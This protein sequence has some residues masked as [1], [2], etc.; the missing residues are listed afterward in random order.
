MR[1]GKRPERRARFVFR[2]PIEHGSTGWGFF[3]QRPPAGP[4]CI[5]LTPCA[6]VPADVQTQS[7]RTPSMPRARRCESIRRNG[8]VQSAG[9]EAY[10]TGWPTS[11]RKERSE[12]AAEP[13]V[14]GTYFPPASGALPTSIGVRRVPMP[15]ISISTTSPG[16]RNSLR[17]APV[18]DGVPVEIRSPG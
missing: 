2:R 6:M 8:Q 11:T 15:S 9:P 1:G 14:G 18:P 12:S 10:D 5:G 3:R 17:S 4:A 13:G 16:L 7:N